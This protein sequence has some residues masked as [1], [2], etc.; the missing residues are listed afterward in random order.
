M[1]RLRNHLAAWLTVNVG[2]LVAAQAHAGSWQSNAPFGATLQGDLYTP[3]TPASPPAVL[4]AIHYCT[5][6]ASNTHG[7]FQSAADQHGFYIIS[8]DAG[9]QCF[10]S[11]ITRGG[12]RAAVVK[13]VDYVVTNKGA[14]RSRVFAAG[15]SSGGCMTNTLLAI[16]P[17][18]FAGG[19]AMPGFTAGGW[20]AGDTT[21]T[22]CGTSPPS[23]DGA[24]WGDMARNAFSFNGT[25]PCSQQWVGG[26]DEYNFNGWLPAVAAQFQNLGNLSAGTPGTGAPNGWTRTVYKDNSG[27]VRLETNLGPGSQKHDLT[28][29]NLFGQVITFLGLDKPTGAC[30]ITTGTGGMGSGGMAAG[31][32]SGGGAPATGGAGGAGVGGDPSTAGGGPS[33]GAGAGGAP[34]TGGMIGSGGMLSAAGMSAGGMTSTGGTTGGS[35]TGGTVAGAPAAGGTGTGGAGATSGSTGGTTMTSGAGGSTGG[36]TTTGGAPG[37]GGATGDAE[38]TSVREGD[39]ACSCRVA[40]GAAHHGSAGL[41]GVAGLG[42]LSALRRRRAGRPL[43]SRTA[44]ARSRRNPVGKFDPYRH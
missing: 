44:A 29:A 6:H 11:S 16:Y 38:A 8:P 20:P 36:G 27:N 17:D 25:R 2:L 1:T 23:T 33:A 3:T 40:V 15:L 19:S 9:K 42:L 39:P 7:W 18:V 14:D 21:C 5:G 41:F 43:R 28:G 13:M 31:G 4:V 35:G 32:T 22:K 34:G 10:D 24:Y 30:G 37:T 26:G 12:D